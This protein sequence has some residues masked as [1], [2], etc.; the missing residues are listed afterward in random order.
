MRRTE[1][2]R[3][4]A[5]GAA[6]VV[7][8]VLVAGAA[9]AAS[10]LGFLRESPITR[11]DDRDFELLQAAAL[12]ALNSRERQAT[13][14]WRNELTGHYGTV[15][16]LG[17]FK[18]DGRTCRRLQVQNRAGR[19]EG[20]ARYSVCRSDTGEWRVEPSIEPPRRQ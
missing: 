2:S 18:H 6:V 16:V 11:F 3:L 12:E 5:L 4:R 19:L 8:G 1:P 7:A 17:S 15:T 14:S 20:E 13:R 9:G 10:Q